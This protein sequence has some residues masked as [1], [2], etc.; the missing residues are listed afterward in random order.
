MQISSQNK[1]K[2]H[3]LIFLFFLFSFSIHAADLKL[4]KNAIII[5]EE[6]DDGDQD[7]LLKLLNENS[8][9]DKVIFHGV[10]GGGDSE[11]FDIADII[12]DFDLDTHVVEY[13]SGGCIFGFLGGNKRTLEKGSQ[14]YFKYFHYSVEAM[15]EIIETEMYLTL[16]DDL[17]S[18]IVSVYSEGRQEIVD[19]FEYMYEREVTTDFIFKTFKMGLDDWWKPR[20]KEL[21]EA[22]FLTE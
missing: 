4:D 15:K 17:P 13:C 22:N 3:F 5:S 19:Y 7:T 2:L 8:N 10:F 21:L 1:I 9:V 20:R 11:S 16:A 14:I 18:F 12:I 6:L